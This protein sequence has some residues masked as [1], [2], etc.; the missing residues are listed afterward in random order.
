M[1]I[2]YANQTLRYLLTI[3]TTNYVCVDLTELYNINLRCNIERYMI[4]VYHC[5]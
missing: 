2:N 4:F 3:K 1:K 5:K